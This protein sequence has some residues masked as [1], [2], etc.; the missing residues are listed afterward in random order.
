MQCRLLGYEEIIFFEIEI[1]SS[2]KNSID[3]AMVETSISLEEVTLST[4]GRNREVVPISYKTINTTEI[5]RNPGANRDISKVLQI[6]PGVATTL[7]YRN[8]ILVRGGSPGENRFYLDGIEVPNINHFAT[9]GSSGGPVGLLNV[10]LIQSVDFRSGGFPANR[11]NAL[12]SVIEINQFN[13][14]DSQLEG[15]IALGSS[16]FGLSLDGPIGRNTV[17]VMSLRRSYLQELFKLLK[18]PFLPTYTDAQF[19]IRSNIDE[20]NQLTLIGL[21]AWD[22]FVLNTEVND[23]EDDPEVLERNAYILN[24]LPVNEQR[25][26]TLGV[27]WDH[28]SPKSKQTWVL[29]RS[30]LYNTANKY[31]ENIEEDDRKLLDY[32]SRETETKFRF[33]STKRSGN[34]TWN[35]GTGIEEG[36]YT[37]RTFQFKPVGDPYTP[38]NFESR[39]NFMKYAVFSQLTSPWLGEKL[40]FDVGLR[41]DFNDYSGAMSNPIDQLS[42]RVALSYSLGRLSINLNTGRYYQLPAYTVLGHRNAAGDLVNRENGVT[43]IRSD[44]YV[45]GL[46]YSVTDHSVLTLE[47]FLKRYDKY[48][49]LVDEQISL[50]NLG[51]DFGVVGNDPVSP[52]SKGKAYG[53]ELLFQKYLTNSFYGLLSYTWVRSA[54]TNTSG[55]Y[56]DASWDNRHVLNLTA[57]IK[58]KRNWELGLKF[59]YLGGAP[60]TP[61]DVALTA[62]RE[63]WDRIQQGVFDWSRLNSERLSASHGLDL[64]LDKKWYFKKTALDL[65]FDVQN[66]YNQKTEGQAYL[67]VVRDDQGN[68]VIDPS[69]PDRYLLKQIDNDSGTLLPS[70]GLVFEF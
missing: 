59:R 48:P 10:N 47:G 34:W 60:F 9:Q 46:E 63:V 7:S 20:D 1:S 5:K 24:V 70:I 30:E 41:S 17:Y 23:G 16:D 25:S 51:A 31:R 3:F 55:R 50:A 61:Y 56:I 49:M 12:S 13:G 33:E 42:P 6:L 52:D 14:N 21:A 27:K 53:L 18:L 4:R 2:K 57:G 29:S 26:H 28:F 44:H 36:R 40:R 54:F 68:P 19:K 69:N 45:A 39:L 62:N 67:D 43:Y 65:Y 58:M 37:N 66:S 22:D 15:S 8:D 11:G 32:N 64:R 38:V 35:I